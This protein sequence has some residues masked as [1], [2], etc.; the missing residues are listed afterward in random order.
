M[1]KNKICFKKWNEGSNKRLRADANATHNKALHNPLAKFTAKGQRRIYIR[2]MK[3][4]IN[5]R[6][7]Y[8][9]G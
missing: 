9:D 6:R 2:C 4:V 7:R 8:A 1:K 5:G 3:P